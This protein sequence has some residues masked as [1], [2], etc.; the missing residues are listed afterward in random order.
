M[1]DLISV[2]VVL[3]VM[4]FMFL[5]ILFPNIMATIILIGVFT[6]VGYRVTKKGKEI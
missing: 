1:R 5:C 3:L 2:I 4:L 6:T